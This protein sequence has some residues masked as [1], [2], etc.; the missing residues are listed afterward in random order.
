MPMTLPT[1]PEPDSRPAEKDGGAESRGIK[2]M[3]ARWLDAHMLE[4]LRGAAIGFPL[5]LLAAGLT[6]ALNIVL[7]RILGA[8]QAGL[9]YLALTVTTLSATLATL[10]LGSV[11]L[12]TTAAGAARGDWGSV[13]T[14]ARKGT[15]IAFLCSVGLTVLLASTAPFLSEVVLG[16]AELATPLR[17]MALAIVPQTQLVLHVRLLRGLK[18]IALSQFLRNID[19]PILTM[20]FLVALGGTYGVN[21]AAWSYSLACFITAALAV[22]MWR[23]MP[24]PASTGPGEIRLREM[25]SSGFPLLQSELL[26]INAATMLMLG[27]MSAP[28]IVAIFGAASQ[29]AKPMRFILMAVNSIAGPKFAALHGLAEGKALGRTARGSGLLMTVVASP[30]LLVLILFPGWIM[31]LFGSGFVAGADVLRVLAIAQFIAVITGSISSLLIMSGHEKLLRNNSVAAF[32]LAILLNLALIPDFG[33]MGAAI[34]LGTSIVF[35]NGLG[36]LQVY[37]RL[38]ILP[39]FMSAP[40]NAGEQD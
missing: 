35:R 20:V 25:L 30:M 10:G 5:R 38:G 40:A 13:D 17:W 19:L 26:L 8:E 32:V 31:G 39:F 6:F 4:V 28:A 23:R 21:G 24:R 27:A 11:L 16:K 29:T 7:A 14:A 15:R 1:N 18:K 22:W 3:L 37:R 12:R 36:A 2:R 33:A 34:S 9:Y